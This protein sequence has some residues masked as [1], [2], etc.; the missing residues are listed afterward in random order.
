MQL[1]LTTCAALA[2][3]IGFISFGFSLRKF[4]QGYYVNNWFPHSCGA[5]AHGRTL[6]VTGGNQGIGFE[7]AREMAERGCNV[8]LCCRSVE[9]AN[10]AKAS[11]LKAAQTAG[12]ATVWVSV[13]EMRTDSFKSTA[14]A[15]K[16]VL[17]VTKG[18]VHYVLLN[19]GSG[20]TEYGV[21]EDNHE[22][23]LQVNYL[24]HFLFLQLL[25]RAN[26]HPL[27][28]VSTSSGAHKRGKLRFEDFDFTKSPGEYTMMSAYGQS[29]L[30]QIVHMKEEA[31][32]GSATVFA[33]YSPGFCRTA[34]LGDS[35]LMRVMCAV[36]YPLLLFVGRSAKCGAQ[37]ALYALLSPTIESGCYASN[38]YIV[39]PTPEA[40][41]E[42][43]GAK[44]WDYS[45]KSVA[46]YL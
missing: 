17:E 26:V 44:L 31:R 33:S 9:R 1:N 11:L 41:S 43:A 42:E 39:T 29:K 13:V 36:F 14:E 19:A 35:L 7:A 32:Q 5:E 45:L 18:N 6:V 4:I 15:A 21:T 34:I 12:H 22:R 8:V 24:S 37:C 20:F 40:C 27:R 10:D 23:S 28:V 30:A 16:K 25:K 46:K 38:L 3:P 2:A